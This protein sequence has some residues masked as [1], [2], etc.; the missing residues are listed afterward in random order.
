[1]EDK[2][3]KDVEAVVTKIFS[4]KEDAEI[5]KQTEDAL[6]KAANTIE[7]LTTALEDKNTSLEEV[8]AKFSDSEEKVENL[9]TELEAAQTK[10]EETTNKL[11]E[12]EIALENLRKDRVAELRIVELEEA[13][14]ISDKETQSTK[15]REM[16]DEEFASYKSELVS[17][18]ES[19]ITEL[20]K[21][22]SDDKGVDAA[23]KAAAEKA[24][25]EKAAAEK[26]AA[27]KAAAEKADADDKSD[28]DGTPSPANINP[29]NAVSAALNLEVFPSDDM[30]T[31]YQAM[32]KAMASLFNKEEKND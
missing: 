13:G 21:K 19:V 1:M 24:A 7:E 28:D 8:E 17:I 5:R 6:S 9:Q 26:E 22:T 2:L 16:S 32:G 4:E 11:K 25:A 27:E 15:V 10:I 14:V 30:V 18:R 31:K 23:E 29:N 12:T 20:S 3:R